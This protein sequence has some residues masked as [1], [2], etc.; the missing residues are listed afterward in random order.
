M[1][2]PRLTRDVAP[3]IHRLEHAHV[4]CYLIEGDDRA[5]GVT[6][7]DTAFP[8]TWVPLIDTLEAIG[9]RPDEVRA[10][11]LTHAHFDHLGMA[12]RV[13]DEWGI[14][15]W[16]HPADAYIAEHPYR[17]LHESPRSLYPIWYP[18]TIPVIGRMVRAGALSVR[19]V[20]GLRDLSPG[21]ELPVPGR[22][23]VVFS[24]GHTAG[25]CALHLPGR[26]VLLS[27]DALVTF[28]PYTAQRGPQVVSGAATAD[29]A[30]AFASLDVLEQTGAAVVLPGHGDAWRGGIGGAV[31]AARRYGPS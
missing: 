6:L 17:Y 10:A 22:P 14:P 31:A 12:R 28:N 9:R 18:R 23:R 13:R 5:E 16:G 15:V 27:G 29:L 11:V 19:G 21:A 4:N 24:P 30:E 20:T 3:G 7:V 1:S 26:G 25:H 8:A 2:R